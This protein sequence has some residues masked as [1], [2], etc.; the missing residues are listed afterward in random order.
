MAICKFCGKAF[1]WGNADGKW[2]PLV[3]VGEDDSLDRAY[4]DENG[5]LRAEHRAV[6]VIRGGPT[7]RV[8]RLAV[9]VPAANVLPSPPEVEAETGE[10]VAQ[11]SPPVEK[12]AR[13]AK[14]WAVA[15][16]L[17]LGPKFNKTK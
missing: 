6:C 9:A 8:A 13:R 11:P 17:G 1:S 4:Q 7:V 3:P 12:R 16:G 2:V 15:A 14:G 5:R 10:I